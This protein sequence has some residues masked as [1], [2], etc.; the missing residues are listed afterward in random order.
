MKTKNEIEINDK[1]IKC[2]I[3]GR[4]INVSIDF[5]DD[6]PRGIACW[7]CYD[8]MG[9]VACDCCEGNFYEDDVAWI[10]NKHPLCADCAEK[11]GLSLCNCCKYLHT[12]L[13]KTSDGDYCE[14]CLHKYC[15]VCDRCEKYIYKYTMNDAIDGSRYCPSCT[16]NLNLRVCDTCGLHAHKLHATDGD[17]H[18][19]DVCSR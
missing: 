16:E 5:Y 18:V 2:E 4:S 6:T 10:D 12:T 19:C 8:E 17:E 13:F 3:C 1:E 11:R 9:L 14:D 7:S 15:I